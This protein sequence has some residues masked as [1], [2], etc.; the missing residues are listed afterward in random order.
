MSLSETEMKS[1]VDFV[2]NISKLVDA[3][4]AQTRIRKA[5]RKF[6]T[7]QGDNK[8]VCSSIS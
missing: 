6:V 4:E 7:K 2:Q 5:Q 3:Y 8:A 1:T